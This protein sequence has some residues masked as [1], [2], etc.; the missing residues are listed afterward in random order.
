MA[1]RQRTMVLVA[2]VLMA[3]GLSV[4]VAVW[5][6]NGDGEAASRAEPI[7]PEPST[8][9]STE[10]TVSVAS[11]GPP[12]S[13]LTTQS[14]EVW[15][16]GQRGIGPVA[17]GMTLDEAARASGL[18]VVRSAPPCDDTASIDGGPSGTYFGILDGRI[19][20]FRS[21]DTAV[22][23]DRGVR[24]GSTTE[25]VLGAYP[26]GTRRTHELLG[27]A[28]EVALPHGLF[29]DFY[30]AVGDDPGLYPEAVRGV[31]HRIDMHGSREALASCD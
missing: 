30:D 24:T 26:G 11:T 16:I 29:L 27:S 20:W 31:V 22:T 23:T 7:A 3:L 4:S 21:D 10:P 17:I 13:A 1:G 6:S 19:A 8:E 2:V 9:A 12:T 25:A 14:P 5:L 18:R 28:Y 15:T